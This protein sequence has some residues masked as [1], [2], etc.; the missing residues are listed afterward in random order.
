MIDAER[1]APVYETGEVDVDA[2]AEVVWDTLTDL[3]S[4][5][6]WMPDVKSVVTRGPFGVGSKF[7]WRAGPGLIR[8][9]VLAANRPSHA[10]W[11]GRTFGIEAVHVWNIEARSAAGCHVQSAESWSG[12]APR[13]LAPRMRKTVRGAL[14]GGLLALKAEAERRSRT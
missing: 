5:P 7:E 14:D 2:S 13:L 10:S 9:E 6:R 11:R 3:A 4:W 12:L 1:D 8:S